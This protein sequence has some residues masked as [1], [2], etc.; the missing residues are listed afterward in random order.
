MHVVSPSRVVKMKTPSTYPDF[1]ANLFQSAKAWRT[2][3]LIMLGVFLAQSAMMLHMASQRTV[4]L[5]PQGLPASKSGIT[6]NLGEPFTPDYLTALAKGDAYSLLSWTPENI[7]AQ[8]G[9][10]LSRLTS[11]QYDSKKGDL[12]T[13]AKAHKDEG[14]TQSFYGSRSFVNGSD[15][16]LYGI[17]IR[18]MGGKEVFRGPAAYTFSYTAAGNGVLSIASVHQPS[19]EEYR[20]IEQSSKGKS[21]SKAGTA[22]Q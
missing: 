13:E 5:I 7:E 11:S 12:L 22:A 2:V 4:L 17:L 16:T 21:G 8:Y 20:S 15:V 14:L 9:L 18:S 3:A 19:E 1:L 6:L 10:F